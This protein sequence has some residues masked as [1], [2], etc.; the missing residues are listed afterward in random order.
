MM[1]PKRAKPGE[2][3]RPVRVSVAGRRPR[4]LAIDV[5]YERLSFVGNPKKRGL[6]AHHVAETCYECFA[7][8][9]LFRE[10]IECDPKDFDGIQTALVELDIQLRH[11]AADHWRILERLL[12]AA[13]R[14]ADI[15]LSKAMKL[16]PASN[17]R[18]RRS[19]KR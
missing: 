8:E 16:R 13:I 15:A 4:P 6:L 1:L 9:N 3:R 10:L 14:A 17:T 12:G 19:G 11:I 5:V 2:L 18:L 7:V